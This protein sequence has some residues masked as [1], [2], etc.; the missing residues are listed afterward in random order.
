VRARISEHVPALRE[1]AKLPNA[2]LLHLLDVDQRAV[3]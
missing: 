1:R 2:A 3:A